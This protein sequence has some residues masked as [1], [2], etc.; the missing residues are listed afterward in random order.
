M[1]ETGTKRV[2]GEA[3]D[4]REPSESGETPAAKGGTSLASDL[5]AM[6]PGADPGGGLGIDLPAGLGGLAIAFGMFVIMS[7]LIAPPS[8]LRPKDDSFSPIDFVRL[9]EESEVR[10]KK[11]ELPNKVL[12]EAPP[13]PD[14]SM[15][16]M[17]PLARGGGLGDSVEIPTFETELAGGGNLSAIASDQDAM[18]LVRMD[19]EYPRRAAAQGI[20]GWVLLQFTITRTGATDDIVVLDSEPPGV[21]DRSAIRAVKRYKY[22]AKVL[23]GELVRQPGMM[24]VLEWRMDQERAIE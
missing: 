13:P 16:R 14:I 12:E 7:F 20:E 6:G 23:D 9:K 8:D 1:S 11:R 24:I 21:F 22:K 15:P 18:P 4:S 3:D 10:T 2:D 5:R 19:H 17:A